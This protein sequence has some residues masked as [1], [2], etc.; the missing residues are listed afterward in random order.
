MMKK[1]KIIENPGVSAPHVVLLGA[2]ASLAAFPNGD[3]NQK[4]LPVMNNLVEVVNLKPLLEKPYINSFGNFETIYSKLKDK[5]I[6]T[7]WRI[8]LLG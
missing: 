6:Q 5:K 1:E 2:G 3:A 4:Q 7:E 8:H